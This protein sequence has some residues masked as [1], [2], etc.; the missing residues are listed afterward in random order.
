MTL[1]QLPKTKMEKINVDPSRV[2]PFV[3]KDAKYKLFGAFFSA[4]MHKE[5]SRR[6]PIEFEVSIG[7][8]D[9]AQRPVFSDS[10][11]KSDGDHYYSLKWGGQPELEVKLRLAIGLSLSLS[12]SCL[13]LSSSLISPPG[14]LI[15]LFLQFLRF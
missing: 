11:C 12:P 14:F 8:P 15:A 6:K 9:P 5:Y 10:N 1:D 13:L 3:H 7:L 2:L 4:T